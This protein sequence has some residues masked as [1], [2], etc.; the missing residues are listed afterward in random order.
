MV[1][2]LWQSIFPYKRLEQISKLIQRRW[3]RSAFSERWCKATDKLPRSGRQ[4]K[5][6]LHVVWC[7]CERCQQTKSLT[8]WE[9]WNVLATKTKCKAY[10]RYVIDFSFTAFLLSSLRLSRSFFY[11]RFFCFCLILNC[12]VLLCFWFF[13]SAL[14]IIIV[15]LWMFFW[16]LSQ[17]RSILTF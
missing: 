5:L 7:V 3:W 13:F 2:Y 10:R 12:F 11:L 4:I 17:H 9:I 16:L 14:S 6:C 15:C 1:K 8:S